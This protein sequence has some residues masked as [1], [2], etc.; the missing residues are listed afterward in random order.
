MADFV[1]QP[2][3]GA[4]VNYWSDGNLN[5]RFDRTLESFLEDAGIG[6]AHG[7]ILLQPSANQYLSDDGKIRSTCL[8][9]C[10]PA[11]LTIH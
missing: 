11:S 2:Q 4:G 7:E 6:S 1:R 10:L 8:P 9:A 5:L 3:N